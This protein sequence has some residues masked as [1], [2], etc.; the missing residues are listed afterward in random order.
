MI[1]AGIRAS[2]VGIAAACVTA[3]LFAVLSSFVLSKQRLADVVGTAVAQN[4]LTFASRKDED[5]F[6]VCALLEM[7]HLRSGG[8]FQSALDTKFLMRDGEHP[9]DTLRTLVLG[10]AEARAALPP[11]VSYFNYPFGSRHLAAF[12]LSALDFG[13]A[14]R[15]YHILSYGSVVLLFLAMLWRAPQTALLLA[16]V[17]LL[18]IGAFSMH[19][20]GDNLGVAP[21]Y[22]IGFLALAFFVAMPVW[23]GGFAAR[24]GFAGAIG[25]VAAYFDLLAGQIPTLLALA[26]LLNY[27][28]YAADRRE[29]ANYF[30]T[31]ATQG[32]AIF[33][34]FVAAIWPC[35][36]AGSVCCGSTGSMF[37]PSP[38]VS[39]PAPHTTLA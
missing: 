24:L 28:F 8:R 16:P 18:L 32:V 5:L 19:S 27:F 37:P 26:I 3:A 36:S 4:Q 33:A 6:T 23:F 15:L 31:A 38:P 20:L 13:Q 22:F 11:A 2:A 34:C 25:V 17:P 10:S 21:G 30:F 39:R 9:C 12:V 1:L 14:T 35:R 7:Q 29:G